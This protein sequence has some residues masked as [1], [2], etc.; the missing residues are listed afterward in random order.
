MTK[1]TNPAETRALELSKEGKTLSVIRANL[2]VEGLVETMGA[3]TKLTKELGLT[4]TK[5]NFAATYYAWL[6]EAKRSKE[7][8]T[9]YISDPANSDNVRKHLSHYLGIWE[10]SVTIWESK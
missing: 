5:T 3:A 10:L 4:S 2:L 6:S 1:K 7:D 9:D 8:A